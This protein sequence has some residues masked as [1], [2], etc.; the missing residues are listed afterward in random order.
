MLIGRVLWISGSALV[1]VWTFVWDDVVGWA[2]GWPIAVAS[3]IVGLGF[4]V[5]GAAQQSVIP[6]LLTEQE[7]LPTAMTLNTVP[8][9]LER[10][11]GPIIGPYV[12]SH[13]GAWEAFAIAAGGH[14]VFMLVLLVISIPD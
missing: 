7:L 1:A 6:R 12:A 11:G 13:L 3:L 4:V 8:M 10:I 14:L 2:D 5:G 9:I